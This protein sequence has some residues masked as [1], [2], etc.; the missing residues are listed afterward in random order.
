MGSHRDDKVDNT[1]KDKRDSTI[2][3]DKKE[4]IV[5]DKKDDKVKDT[6]TTR[7]VNKLESKS[8]RTVNTKIT[9]TIDGDSSASDKY[10]PA[11]PTG[12]DDVEIIETADELKV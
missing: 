4:S 5:R 2:G 3:K 7:P 6:K 9:I 12:D 11:D 1:N 8:E 10:D